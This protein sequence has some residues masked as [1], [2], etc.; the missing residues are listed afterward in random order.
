MI[1][2]LLFDCDGV[3][4]DSEPINHRCWSEAFRARFGAGLPGGASGLVG[5]DL[6]AIYRLGVASAGLSVEVLDDE[7]RRALLADKSAL[8]RQIAPG[9]LRP[10]RG[11]P[12]LVAAAAARGMPRGVVSFALRARLQLTLD[13]VGMGG[14]WGAVLA[15]EDSL[16]G[17][18]R[19]KDWRRAAALLAVPIERCAVIEDS[20]EGV[21][22]ARR[23]GAGLVLGVATAV[24][25][26][27]L[28]AAGAHRVSPG[29]WAIDIAQVVGS[30]VAP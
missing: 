15:G 10:V 7:T 28:Q 17:E 2:G 23:A 13:L 24:E 16:P 26:A 14:G 6:E 27:R 8:F 22:S 21:A 11:A 29:P 4:A 18:P 3:L 19:Q 20:A 25:A 9:E 12:E 30:G 5:L 1:E